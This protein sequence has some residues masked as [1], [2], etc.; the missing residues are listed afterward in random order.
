MSPWC[1]ARAK[2]ALRRIIQGPIFQLRGLSQAALL[3]ALTP[4]VDFAQIA[5]GPRFVHKQLQAA[6][7]ICLVHERVPI[8]IADVLGPASANKPHRHYRPFHTIAINKLS[9][10]QRLA[11]HE[12]AR[13]HPRLAMFFDILRNE[14]FGELKTGDAS[15]WKR[16]IVICGRRRPQLDR[17][18]LE[19]LR[20]FTA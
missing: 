5:A 15:P 13:S 18:K 10:R 9:P 16:R 8:D 20:E 14:P 12:Q 1:K 7:R 4:N 3:F 19:Y 2:A 17:G 11:M 6:F